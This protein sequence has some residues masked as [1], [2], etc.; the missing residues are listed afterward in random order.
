MFS[1][2]SSTFLRDSVGYVMNEREHNGVIRND[3]I[4]MLISIRK[5]DEDKPSKSGVGKYLTRV[6]LIRSKIIT[7]NG[8]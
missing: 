8:L 1:K 3:L 4:D 6:H 5:E 7:S 2:Q